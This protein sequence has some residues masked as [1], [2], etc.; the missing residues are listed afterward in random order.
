M[1]DYAVVIPVREFQ[2]TK[3]R[4]SSKL[5]ERDRTALTKGLLRRVLKQV[6]K[7]SAIEAVII[8]SDPVQVKD[9][10]HDL[11]KVQVFG[12]SRHH[13]GVNSAMENGIQ[14]VRESNKDAALFLMPSD[15]PFLTPT[16]LD[17]VASMLDTYDLI[18]NPAM[19]FD[20]TS[21]LAFN[22]DTGRIP[23]HYDD[24]SFQ[25]HATEARNLNIR[26]RV[27]HMIEFSFDVD[28]ESDVLE[29]E[30]KIRAN[31]FSDLIS[32]LEG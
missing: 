2:N 16:A 10:I 27:I 29:M 1:R 30:E 7:S 14:I 26:H 24:N 15:L 25:K 18:I 19:K 17:E 5:N 22:Y 11:P 3:L 4:L 20:G 28:S 8:A 6:L 23:L 12:E 21:L 31:S 32:K 13:G 9:S